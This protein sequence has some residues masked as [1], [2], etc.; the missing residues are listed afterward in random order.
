MSYQNFIPT[1]WAE[2]IERELERRCVFA[3]NCNRKYEGQ[4]K[5]KGDTVRI[6]G[7]GKPTIITTTDKNITL[8]SPEVVPDTSIVMPIEQISFFNYEVGDI[9]RHQAVGG[10]MEALSKETSECLA[11]EMD[12]HIALTAADKQAVK[13]AQSAYKIEQSNIL[14]KI[15]SA[16][17]ILWENNVSPETKITLTCPPRFYF[18]LKR[19]YVDLDTDN[20]KIMENGKVGR[21]GN[22]EIKLSNQ[23]ATAES[24]A[25]DLIQ[26]KTDR[27]IAFVN[28]LTHTEPYR[29]ENRFSDAVKGFVLYQAKIVRPKEMVVM[30]VKYQ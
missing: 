9:D 5:E 27:A 10:V 14:E 29:P 3:E 20:S 19:A 18:L 2:E 13:H 30:N 12:K 4:V 21:Y 24:G 16:L 8:D 22:I 1:V 11:A 23:V 28:P 6:L 26:V 15:D 25:V 7:V 17:Q